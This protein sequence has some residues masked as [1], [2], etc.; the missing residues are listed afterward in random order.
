MKVFTAK[1]PNKGNYNKQSLL[2][3]PE[4]QPL[5]KK[6]YKPNYCF[7]SMKPGAPWM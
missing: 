3:N 4:A 6:K 5:K 1:I 2:I 7:Q